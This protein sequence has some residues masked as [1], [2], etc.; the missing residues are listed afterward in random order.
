MCRKINVDLKFLSH[1]LLANKI[2]LNTQ[3]T[4][5]IFFKKPL[6]VLPNQNKIKMNGVRLIPCSYIKYLGIY[7]DE[8]LTWTHHLNQLNTKLIRGNS[9][10]AIARIMSLKTF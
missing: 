6:K 1:W 2:S 9:M 10:L 7:I 8:N 3:K 5:L 4:E